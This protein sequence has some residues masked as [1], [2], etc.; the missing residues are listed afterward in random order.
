MYKAVAICIIGLS[1]S[2]CDILEELVHPSPTDPE[3]K[4]DSGFKDQ[5]AQLGLSEAVINRL[6][7]ATKKIE[8]HC[9]NVVNA[10]NVREVKVEYTMEEAVISNGNAKSYNVSRVVFHLETDD[11]ASKVFFENSRT[12]KQDDGYSYTWSEPEGYDVANLVLSSDSEN[13]IALANMTTIDAI[14]TSELSEI[15]YTELS[16]DEYKLVAGAEIMDD[17]SIVE[18][19]SLTYVLTADGETEEEDTSFAMYTGG[20]ANILGNF[21]PVIADAIEQVWY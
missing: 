8:T 3:A 10:N 17:I 2:G 5:A 11:S 4:I 15:A 1:L 20:H 12:Y 21:A 18:F 13:P 7:T 19:P 16:N 9:I 6:C 14:S